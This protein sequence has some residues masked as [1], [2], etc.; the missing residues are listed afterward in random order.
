MISWTAPLPVR[1]RANR[2]LLGCPAAAQV[3][4]L[5]CCASRLTNAEISGAKLLIVTL[6]LCRQQL[7]EPR[8]AANLR[9]KPPGQGR[10]ALLPVR[11]RANRRL[12]GCPAAAQVAAL[13]CFASR[14][15]NA[16]I[17]G[18]KLLIVTLPLCRQQ[19]CEPRGAANLRA[20]PPG[21]GRPALLPVRRRANR[22]LLGCP[23][24]AQVAALCCCASRL[25]NAE[26]SGA[27]LLIVTL[28]LCRQQLCEPRGAANLRAKPPG[29]GRPALLPVRRRAIED[30]QGSRPLRKSLRFVAARHGSQTPKLAEPNCLTA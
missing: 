9:A 12:L 3:A 19:L 7:C 20:K 10:P 4:S 24:A 15:T 13:C 14:L 23:A 16:E 5:C 30:C 17:S 1:R 22:R 8:G 28:P 26:I 2:R 29:Q 25:T 27:K 21:Q 11:R 18:A 6:P